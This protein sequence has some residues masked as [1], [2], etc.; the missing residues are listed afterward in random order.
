MERQRNYNQTFLKKNKIEVLIPA[1]FKTY[2]KA[3]IVKTLC[4]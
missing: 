1:D 4:Y 3:M 2:Y